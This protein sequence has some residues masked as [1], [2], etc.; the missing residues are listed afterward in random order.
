MICTQAGMSGGSVRSPN[1][2]RQI[3]SHIAADVD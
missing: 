2:Q 1:M 3:H